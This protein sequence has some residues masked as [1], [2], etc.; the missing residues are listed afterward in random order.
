[1]VRFWNRVQSRDGHDL[2]K[3][4]ML[5][6]TE[7]L[8]GPGSSWA[9][10]F[11]QCLQKLGVSAG[12]DNLVDEQSVIQR[13][14]DLWLSRQGCV[15][16]VERV[17]D[18]PDTVHKNIKATTYMTWF[19]SGRDSRS[20]F[21][22]HLDMRSHIKIVAKFRMGCSW[23]N[24][25]TGRWQKV[26]RSGRVCGCST[27]VG[28]GRREDEAHLIECPLYMPL[29]TKYH[30]DECIRDDMDIEQRFR[31]FMTPPEE[32][33]GQFWSRVAGFLL[34]ARK[35]RKCDLESD[36]LLDPV[37]NNRFIVDI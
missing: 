13:A 32:G 22:Y 1:V 35:L 19:A 37:I 16:A 30:L 14:R 23:L 5:E 4:A 27:C 26:P 10:D 17:R 15:Q 25:E 24:I 8:A 7:I 3:M 36:I 18:I 31:G 34:H 11:F 9:A 29:L 6:S 20:R 12:V 33:L 28:M 2:V 21:W